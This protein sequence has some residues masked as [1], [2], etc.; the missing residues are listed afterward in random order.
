MLGGKEL[1]GDTVTPPLRE[2]LQNAADAIR[3]RRILDGHEKNWGLIRVGWG[4]D[5]SGKWIEVSDNG[6]GMS[7]RVLSEG[8]LDF[9][10]SFW[11]SDMVQE[12]LAG[13]IGTGFQPTGRY[14]IGFFS[15]FMWGKRVE[16]TSRRFDAARNET[17]VLAFVDGLNLRP[18]KAAPD[19]AMLDSGKIEGVVG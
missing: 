2:L 3:A 14:G 13:L 4:E 19:E 9:G 5:A 7:P 16:V 15:V 11:S 10:K 8:L 18:L 6:V 1:Y 12:E 17:H